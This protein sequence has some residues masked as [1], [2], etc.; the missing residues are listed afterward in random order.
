MECLCDNAEFTEA[1]EKI[2]Q[3]IVILVYAVGG[4]T[5]SG[6]P[7]GDILNDY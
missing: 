7:L 1:L 5:G 3:K 4:S 2:E 6:D